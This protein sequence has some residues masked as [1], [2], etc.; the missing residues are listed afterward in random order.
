M[1]YTKIWGQFPSSQPHALTGLIAALSFVALN[2]EP[3][4]CAT[5]FAFFSRL[6]FRLS[7]V[8]KAIHGAKKMKISISVAFVLSH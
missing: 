8:D 2:A 5:L 3:H 6:A 4:T 1:L 7:F